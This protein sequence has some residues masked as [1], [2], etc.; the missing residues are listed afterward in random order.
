MTK[1]ML[2]PKLRCDLGYSAI[3]NRRPYSEI[4]VVNSLQNT[5]VVNGDSM[6]VVSKVRVWNKKYKV[7]TQFTTMQRKH[8]KDTRS[9]IPVDLIGKRIVLEK[10]HNPDK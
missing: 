9:F 6:R 5:I 3:Q 1:E 7:F 2:Q 4:S 10:Q 8:S